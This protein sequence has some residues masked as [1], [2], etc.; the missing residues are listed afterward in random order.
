LVANVLSKSGISDFYVFPPNETPADV[1]AD[2][3]WKTSEVIGTLTVAPSIKLDDVTPVV[4][5]VDAQNCKGKFISG[6]IPDD[7]GAVRLFT[8]CEKDAKSTTVFYVAAPRKS[9]G[10]YLLAT[11]SLGEDQ[12]ARKADDNIRS[13]IQQVLFKP[14]H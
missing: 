3:V 7:T 10:S 8:A 12:S 14:Q 13:A 9:G 5:A 2:V 4:I 6:S 1:R 11:M